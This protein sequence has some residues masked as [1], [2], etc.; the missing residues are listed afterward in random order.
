MDISLILFSQKLFEGKLVAHFLLDNS[1]KGFFR[2]GFNAEHWWE[3]NL[4][5]FLTRSVIEAVGKTRIGPDRI[6]SDRQN[7]DRINNKVPA[8]SRLMK[9]LGHQLRLLSTE[10]PSGKSSYARI[11]TNYTS[12][13][14]LVYVVYDKKYCLSEFSFW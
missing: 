13:G 6:G 2:K 12:G 14:S 3:I 9:F 11:V 1:S 7:S 5:A 10:S 4:V 8:Q